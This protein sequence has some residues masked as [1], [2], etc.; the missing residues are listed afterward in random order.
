MVIEL[1]SELTPE[2]IGNN[3]NQKFRGKI[4]FIFAYWFRHSNKNESVNLFNE[5]IKLTHCMIMLHRLLIY[6]LGAL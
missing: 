5:S 4:I 2:V 6:I 1:D 3:T